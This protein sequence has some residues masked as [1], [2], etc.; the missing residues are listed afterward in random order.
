L[1]DEIKRIFLKGLRK[2]LMDSEG[3]LKTNLPYTSRLPTTYLKAI[4]CIVR[5]LNN[6]QVIHGDIRR[7]E[8]FSLE[9]YRKG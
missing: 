3:K 9:V 8:A 5:A 1:R 6:A 7:Y 4:N 2:L